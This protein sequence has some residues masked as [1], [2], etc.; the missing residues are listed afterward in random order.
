MNP[1]V[2]AFLLGL[3]TRLQVQV[4]GYLPLS[5]L[6]ILAMSPFLLPQFTRRDVLRPTRLLVPLAILWLLGTAV[7]DLVNETQW[8]LAARGL[9]RPL[10]FLVCIPFC[11][12]FFG[13]D[14]W[15]RLLWF[16]VGCVPSVVLSAFVLRGGVHEAREFQRGE[17]EINW[18]THWCALPFAIS[19]VL[20][21]VYYQRRPIRAY[22]ASLLV[23]LLNIYMGSRSL[24]GTSILGPAVCMVRNILAQRSRGGIWIRRRLTLPRAG[25]AIAFVLLAAFATLETYRWAAENDM[26]GEKAREKYEAQSRSRF[27]LLIGGRAEVLAGIIAVSKSPIIG[28]GSWPLDKQGFYIQMCELLDEKPNMLFYKTGYPM[29]PCHSHVLQA[30]VQNGILGGVFW[31][32][33]LFFVIARSV[34]RPMVDESRLRLW[35]SIVSINTVWVVLFSPISDRLAMCVTL[36]VMLRQMGPL[37]VS[38]TGAQASALGNSPQRMPASA[39]LSQIHP[40]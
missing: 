12:W 34:Y 31:L 10:V 23:G 24:G 15:R 1:L 26:L 21:L 36:V 33:V 6:A 8:S 11:S 32:Y 14:T 17:A 28:Y 27:G 3:G 25:V 5:E 7:T 19:L 35:E 9:A 40:T 37:L 4:I 18:V 38:E 29:I 20:A 2:V 39:P 16:S 22:A 13:T 30:W